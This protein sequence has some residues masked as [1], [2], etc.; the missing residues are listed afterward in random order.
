MTQHKAHKPKGSRSFQFTA[1]IFAV[2]LTI[3]PALA[4]LQLGKSTNLKVIIV[5]VVT[6]SV[7]TYYAYWSDKRKAKRDKWRTPETTLHA[8]EFAGGWCAAFV[9]QR[10]LRHKISKT[11][12]QITFW[13]IAAV[14][15]YLAFDYLG[16]SLFLMETSL[17]ALSST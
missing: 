15:Q 5:Y 2:L 14:H 17:L 9:A 8:L 1:K 6:I 4:V 3:L 16:S 10:L 12:Y 7:I 11:K 13:M